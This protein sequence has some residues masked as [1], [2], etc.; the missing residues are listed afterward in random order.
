MQWSLSTPPT[1]TSPNTNLLLFTRNAS[2]FSRSVR[3][4]KLSTKNAH[5]LIYRCVVDKNDQQQQKTL[6]IFIMTQWIFFTTIHFMCVCRC[7]RYFH[8]HRWI[9]LP[10]GGCLCVCTVCVVRQQES[11]ECRN[12]LILCA[13]TEYKKKK[14]REFI[15]CI[16]IK[17]SIGP[18]QALMSYWT[19]R[20]SR[21][22]AHNTRICYV[23][24][25]MFTT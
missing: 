1:R 22:Y 25:L 9:I 4:L 16:L 19:F 24:I 6:S 5:Q 23:Y 7:T 10:F 20:V 3:K 17:S 14:K 18:K 13:R 21:Y 12:F 2:A 11:T 8:V 15:G